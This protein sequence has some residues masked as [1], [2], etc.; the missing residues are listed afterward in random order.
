MNEA[1]K[2][3]QNEDIPLLSTEKNAKELQTI[4]QKSKE[5]ELISKEK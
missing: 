4:P 1:K 5:K 3:K 2:E